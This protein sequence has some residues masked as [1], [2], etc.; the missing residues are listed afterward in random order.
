MLVQVHGMS[1]RHSVGP[2]GSVSKS[3]RSA[4]KTTAVTRGGDEA[5]M[6]GGV[7]WVEPDDAKPAE[8][9]NGGR[10]ASGGR[11]NDGG[12]DML[13]TYIVL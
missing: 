12:G 4:S 9:R 10:G 13:C 11:G 8:G 7:R 6:E 1:L 2:T 5:G 3:A